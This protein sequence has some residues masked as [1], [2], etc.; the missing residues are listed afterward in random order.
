MPDAR[1]T[2]TF[3][4][5]PSGPCKVLDLQGS[6]LPAA[7]AG[8]RSF[9]IPRGSPPDLAQV[10]H[11]ESSGHCSGV[12]R[13]RTA[14]QAMRERCVRGCP[15]SSTSRIKNHAGAPLTCTDNRPALPLRRSPKPLPHRPGS[16]PRAGRRWPG[17]GRWSCADNRTT[18]SPSWSS[19]GVA[20]AEV[21][22]FCVRNLPPLKGQ[23]V[24]VSRL[25]T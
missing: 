12:G 4:T 20:P 9:A 5:L 2:S 3:Q 17:H 10:W 1:P 18:M 6:A 8:G 16:W 19:G 11:D 24:T 23:R 22:H 15:S 21:H 7:G 14:E 13:R 25:K